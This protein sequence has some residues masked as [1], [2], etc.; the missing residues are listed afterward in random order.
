MQ[1]RSELYEVLGY[2]AYE[3]RLD[4]LFSRDREREA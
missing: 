3:R 1:T 2:H 4:E